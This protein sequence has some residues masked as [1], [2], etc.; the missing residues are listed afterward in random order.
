MSRV[1]DHVQDTNGEE[2]FRLSTVY[3][4]PDFVKKADLDL[5]LRPQGLP[6]TV[7]G[8]PRS[9]IYPCHNAAS[10]YLS[11]LYFQE[12]KAEFAVKDQRQI[13]NRIDGYADYFGI[14]ASVDAMRDA[15]AGLHKTAESQLA[16][17]DFAYVWTNANQQKQRKFPITTAMEVKEAAEY[18][19]KHQ[20]AI[21]FTVRHQIATRVLEKVA[22]YGVGLGTELSDYINRQ[23]GRGVCDIDEVSQMVRNRSHLVKSAQVKQAF[24]KMA[25]SIKE[26][27]KFEL[28]PHNLIKL[29][30]TLDTL[31]RKHGLA[32]KYCSS[33][34]RPEDVIF[35][36]TYEKAASDLSSVVTLTDGKL[37]EKQA[38]SRLALKDVRDLFGDEFAERVRTPLGQV[39]IEKFAEEAATLPR[40]EAVALGR[41]LNDV[42]V[43]PS[44]TKAASDRQGFSGE[45][46][47][48]LAESYRPPASAPR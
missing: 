2:L 44:L 8:D 25:E 40:G 20:D 45:Q 33:L 46:W 23:A 22:N 29:A 42:G 36:V 1:L 28:T 9:Q 13:L 21:P 32:G 6:V 39:D 11:A 43:G 27:G 3:P 10:T 7:Y 17:S 30:E 31:D 38:L 37:Y 5:T 26:S 19:R 15:W 4:L 14:R 41:L 47:A 48:K 35:K 16:D 12:K 18:I 24:V 34:P